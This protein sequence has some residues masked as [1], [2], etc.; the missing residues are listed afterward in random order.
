MPDSQGA[1]LSGGHSGWGWGLDFWGRTWGMSTVVIWGD[2]LWKEA[3]YQGEVSM[4]G[5]QH[6]QPGDR[7]PEGLQPSQHPSDLPTPV[8]R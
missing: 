8:N 4:W 6:P 2:F 7:N 1:W 3:K 5:T